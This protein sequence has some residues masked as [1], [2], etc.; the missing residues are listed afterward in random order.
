[1]G[2]THYFPQTR[3]F[4]NDE[5]SEIVDFTKTLVKEHRNILANAMGEAGTEPEV[6]SDHISLNGIED[7]SHETFEITRKHNIGFNFTKTARKEYD[8][9]VVAILVYVHRIAPG[10]LE[11][12]SDGDV[13]DWAAGVQAAQNVSPLTAILSCPII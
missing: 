13:E 12:S 2:Y 8:D 5:W 4:T 11:I 1:M 7:A 10:A 9:V 6:T 3:D